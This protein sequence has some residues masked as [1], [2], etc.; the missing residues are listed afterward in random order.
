M[1]LK[2]VALVLVLFGFSISGAQASETAGIVVTIKPLHSLVSGVMGDTGSAT[3]LVAGASSP[4][5]FQFKPSQMKLLHKAKLVFY[6]GDNFETFLKDAFEIIPRHVVKA[7]VSKKAKLRLLPLRKGGVW[8]EDQHEGHNHAEHQHE[9]EHGDDAVRDMHVWLDPGNASRIISA[10]TKEL[11]ALYPENRTVYKANARDYIEKIASLNLELTASLANVKEKPF[12]VFHDG[13]QYFE[14]HYG[15]RAAGS[16]TL[17]PHEFP[18]PNRIK[19]IREKL[20]QTSTVCIFREPQFSNRLIKTI[21]EGTSAKHGILDPLGARID[22]G[23][24]LYFK[25]MRD[26]ADNFKQCLSF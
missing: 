17:D 8:E 7:P 4:H 14:R 5:G 15:L 20:K 25:L 26:M 23:P 2:S 1:S 9:E 12:I 10:I 3:L 21:T 16:I 13:Y 11:G 6:I 24:M 22:D 18:S 19:E